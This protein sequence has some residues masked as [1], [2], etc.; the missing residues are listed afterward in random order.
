MRPGPKR[1]PVADRLWAKVDKSGGPDACWLFTGADNG[2]DYPILSRPG[3]STGKTPFYAHRLAY[4]LAHGVDYDDLPP[5][6]ETRHSCHT[7]RCCNPKHL[8]MGT[9]TDN[10]QDSIADGRMHWQRPGSRDGQGRFAPITTT[11]T[12]ENHAP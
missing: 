12:T 4:A 11:T 7:R 8:L 5:D 1:K 2:R 9:S 3:D 6:E 10:K